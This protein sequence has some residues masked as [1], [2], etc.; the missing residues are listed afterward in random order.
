[1]PDSD[2]QNAKQVGVGLIVVGLALATAS[3]V[4]ALAASSHMAAGSLCGPLARHCI[5]CMAAAASLLASSGVVV[6]GIL[7]L[8]PG[9][10][11]QL[12]LVRN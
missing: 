3:V 11:A 7:L 9:P 8:W 6:S 2:V 1:M 5:L 4:V 12:C 10:F